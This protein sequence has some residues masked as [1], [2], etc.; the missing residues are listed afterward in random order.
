MHSILCSALAAAMLTPLGATL[1]ALANEKVE[2]NLTPS[3][4]I[5]ALPLRMEALCALYSKYE[6]C[7]P[8]IKA[9]QIS[10]N[11]P[12]D[13]VQLNV[14]DIVAINI[15]DARRTEFNYIIGSAS[16]LIFGPYGLLNLLAM[17]RIGDVDFGFTYL[18]NGKRRTA[19]IRFKN[20][21]S[22]EKFAN[23]IKPFLKAV[24]AYQ[25]QVK[26]GRQL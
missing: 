25:A 8:T 4:D 3:T 22:V 16:T 14:E 6:V 23:A 12:T 21:N 2:K 5:P 17:K 20:N 1:P 18:E 13:F 19:F 26:S 10:A 9:T 7:H 15:Y 24:D 11:F